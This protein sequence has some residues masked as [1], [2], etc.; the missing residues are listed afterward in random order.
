MSKQLP[1]LECLLD[2]NR[3]LAN[4][5]CI[6]YWESSM[7]GLW[8]NEWYGGVSYKD[9]YSVF[10]KH[11]CPSATGS[12]GR[13]QV[14]TECIVSC[15]TMLQF[16]M[17]RNLTNTC[18]SIGCLSGECWQQVS[19]VK[20]DTA[21]VVI[22]SFF[23]CKHINFLSMIWLYMPNMRHCRHMAAAWAISA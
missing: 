9:F 7:T 6:D 17:G 19:S 18:K 22:F 10:F 16:V 3:H 5:L 11:C 20:V 12:W 21:A 2:S 1:K 15:F 8:V 4:K 13:F 14:P 23:G